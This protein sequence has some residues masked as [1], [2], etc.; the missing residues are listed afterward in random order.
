[1]PEL[2]RMLIKRWFTGRPAELWIAQLE[3][4]AEMIEK[5]GLKPLPHEH[6][7]VMEVFNHPGPAP[8]SGQ[9]VK[10]DIIN[11]RPF[12]GG[13]R[14]PHLHY[15]DEI[16]MLQEAQWRDFS[17][18]VMKTLRSKMGRTRTVSFDQLVEVSSAIDG[19]A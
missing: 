12:P 8:V 13:L 10:S 4:V 3:T 15:K 1:M 11:P 16:F 19:L 17:G 2:S 5:F 7:P 9:P 14:I 18:R 6:Y